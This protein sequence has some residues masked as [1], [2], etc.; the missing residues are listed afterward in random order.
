MDRHIIENGRPRWMDEKRGA[1]ELWMPN[2]EGAIKTL[3]QSA[4]NDDGWRCAPQQKFTI[5]NYMQYGVSA[6]PYQE[7]CAFSPPRLFSQLELV[8]HDIR[9]SGQ[10]CANILSSVRQSGAQQTQINCCSVLH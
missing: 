3:S 2:N 8:Q 5:G 7:I 9:A 10:R 1:L 4:K 6:L